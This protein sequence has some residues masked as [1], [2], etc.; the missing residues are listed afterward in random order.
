MDRKYIDKKNTKIKLL[1]NQIIKRKLNF[2]LRIK[3]YTIT[4]YKIIKSR[5]VTQIHIS[6]VLYNLRALFYHY[7][8]ETYHYRN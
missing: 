5:Y 6:N 4:L 8:V 1:F 3:N 7:E 2:I